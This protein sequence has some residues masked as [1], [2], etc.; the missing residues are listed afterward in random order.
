MPQRAVDGERVMSTRDFTSLPIGVKVDNGEVRKCPYCNR[1]GVLEIV[2]GADWY[3]HSETII[4][5]PES[6]LLR[7]DMCPQRDHDP[8]ISADGNGPAPNHR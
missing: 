4:A 6:P 7:W 2:N 1:R 3:I 5:D 8:T